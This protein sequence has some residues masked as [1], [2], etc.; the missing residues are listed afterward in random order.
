MHLERSA[1][2][3]ETKKVAVVIPL[4]N[5]STFTADEEISYRQLVHFLGRYDRYFI[6]PKSLKLEFPESCI[7]RFDDRY[8]GSIIAH[9]KLMLSST[10]YDAFSDYE[11]ILIHHLDALVFSDQLLEWCKE[12]FDYIGPPWIKCE[13]TPWVDISRVGNGGLSLRK[14]QSF[15]RVLDSNRYW[16]DPHEY[17]KGFCQ[18]HPLHVQLLNLPRKFLKRLVYFNNV[19]HELAQWPFRTD[20]KGNEDYFW[21]DEAIRYDPT[22]NVAPFKAGLRFAFEVDPRLCYQMNNHQLPFGCHAW[23]RYDRAFWEP[24]LLK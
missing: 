6:A 22:F 11:Y 10:F 21:S 3:Q 17:W 12:G 13:A 24:H 16:V 9:T 8:F 14:I 19:T 18:T 23:P 5:R 1:Q 15:L 20:G 7:R 4:S 2:L